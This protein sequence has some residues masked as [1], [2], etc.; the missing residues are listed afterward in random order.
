M[1]GVGLEQSG[2]AEGLLCCGG[3][4]LTRCLVFCK[5]FLR[6]LRISSSLSL[7]SA[8]RMRSVGRVLGWMFLG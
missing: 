6:I 5:L 4:A 2:G 8:G 3:R 7:D 1:C